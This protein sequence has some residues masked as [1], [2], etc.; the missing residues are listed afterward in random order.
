[1]PPER[2]GRKV[3]GL[4]SEAKPL[5][6]ANQMP[7]QPT[8]TATATLMMAPPLRTHSESETGEKAMKVTIQ[9]KASSMPRVTQMLASKSIV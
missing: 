2:S 6:A 7:T 5:V 8:M 9:V 4:M 3:A 1:M